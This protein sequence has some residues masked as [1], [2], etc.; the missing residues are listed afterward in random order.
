MTVNPD[1]AHPNYKHSC[2]TC[3]ACGKILLYIKGIDA[4]FNTQI[5]KTLMIF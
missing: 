2:M 3:K 5:L 4:S 1:Q